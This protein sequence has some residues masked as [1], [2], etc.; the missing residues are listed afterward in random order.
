MV[1]VRKHETRRHD[2]AQVAA[3]QCAESRRDCLS[4]P[5]VPVTFQVVL[6]HCTSISSVVILLSDKLISLYRRY[7]EY[8]KVGVI[9]HSRRG[10]KLRAS[11]K[12]C[13]LTKSD[14]WAKTLYLRCMVSLVT[15]ELLHD[16]YLPL[17]K[18]IN[19]Y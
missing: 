7:L 14:I 4:R 3:M 1:K 9:S 8:Y 16:Y 13:H 12:I 6:S 10:L 17:G 19:P 18:T 15:L 2:V 5:R 11:Q